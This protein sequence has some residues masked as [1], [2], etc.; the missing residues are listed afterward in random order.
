MSIPKNG[1]TLYEPYAIYIGPSEPYTGPTFTKKDNWDKPIKV[2]EEK[3][4]VM[5]DNRNISKDS[6]RFGFVPEDHILGKAVFII[7]P[8]HRVGWVY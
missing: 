1:I 6:R 7:W 3:Y 8:P 4:F 5:G 2:P